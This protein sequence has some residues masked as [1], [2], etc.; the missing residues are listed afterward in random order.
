[1][2][3]F[4][5]AVKSRQRPFA[6]VEVGHTS[7]VPCHLG[8]IAYRTGRTIHWDAQKEEVIG[9]REASHQLTKQYRAPW[10]LPAASAV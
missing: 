1:M 9:D 7:I 6:D 5:D 2:Q 4:L 3:K 8:N 10:E